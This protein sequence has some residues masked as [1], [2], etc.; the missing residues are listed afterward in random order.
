LKLTHDERYVFFLLFNLPDTPLLFG[1]CSCAAAAATKSL[2][3][4]ASQSSICVFTSSVSTFTGLVSGGLA[5]VKTK[6]RKK[7]KHEWLL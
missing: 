2:L 4:L 6:E 5:T 3:P 1:F 7:L